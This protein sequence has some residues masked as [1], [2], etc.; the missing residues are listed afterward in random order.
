MFVMEWVTPIDKIKNPDLDGCFG[1][2]P[3]TRVE[4]ANALLFASNY[5][6]DINAYPN[7]SQISH[8][9][10]VCLCVDHPSKSV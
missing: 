9:L 3:L 2:Y 8:R 1:L 4:M 7:D 10:D 5:K 6:L